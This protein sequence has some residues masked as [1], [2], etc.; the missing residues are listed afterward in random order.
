[1]IQF[2]VSCLR[3]LHLFECNAFHR[4][5]ILDKNIVTCA[6]ILAHQHN[7]TF[8]R[9]TGLPKICYVFAKST[10]DSTNDSSVPV[11]KQFV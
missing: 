4:A 5:L 3:M 2:F 11:A 9:L 7:V 1:M 8:V 6:H 10:N